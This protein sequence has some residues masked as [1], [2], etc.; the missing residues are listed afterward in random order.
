MLVIRNEQR[1]ERQSHNE[2]D[3][4]QQR[5]PYRQRQQ[6]EHRIDAHVF[7]HDS[8]REHKVLNGL[9]HTINADGVGAHHPEVAAT[10]HGI[11]QAQE[12]GNRYRHQL[13]IRHH[14]QQSDEQAQHHSHWQ[15][16]NRKPYG[17]HHAYNSSNQCLRTEIKAHASL[18]I[19]YHIEH[20]I[21]VAHRHRRMHTAHNLVIVDEQE[22][23]VKHRHQP[24]AYIGYHPCGNTQKAPCALKHAR[25]Q[26]HPLLFAQQPGNAL[27]IDVLQQK[28]VN[29]AWQIIHVEAMCGII[30]QQ[31]HHSAELVE[32]I[33]QHHPA[34]SHQSCHHLNKRHNRRQS[35][36]LATQQS[37]I[38]LHSRVKHICHQARHEKR[39]QHSA[40]IVNQIHHRY[41]Y[42]GGKQNA[43]HAVEIVFS[44]CF[45]HIL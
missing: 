20:A 28:I 35:I 41:H 10:C 3:K 18:Y 22:N 40:E 21:A 8:R 36:A 42:K 12:Y 9:H 5:A 26:L 4:S 29:L 38:K 25:N 23:Q 32:H 30:R 31:R 16:N 37:A 2:S 7:A 34:K 45:I 17:K 24:R 27:N 1:R 19:A 43:H 6:D 33:G 11:N 13:Q 44:S 14:V 15:A 39:Q